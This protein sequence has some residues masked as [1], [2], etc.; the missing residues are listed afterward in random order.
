[1]EHRRSNNASQSTSNSSVGGPS[2]Y[3]DAAATGSPSKGMLL[4]QEQFYKLKALALEKELRERAERSICR[5]GHRGQVASD[6]CCQTSEPKPAP[7]PTPVVTTAPI[8]TI[9]HDAVA[10]SSNRKAVA[11]RSIIDACKAIP[12]VISKESQTSDKSSS[13]HHM[14]FIKQPHSS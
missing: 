9:S 3:K 10:S 12:V 14:A 13:A 6:V 7:S 8:P 11:L 2:H 5:P 1:M 4:S